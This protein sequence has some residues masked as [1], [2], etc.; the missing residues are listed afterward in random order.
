MTLGQ[1]GLGTA[2]VLTNSSLKP[3]GRRTG[4]QGAL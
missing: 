3:L 1:D 4:L 2:E